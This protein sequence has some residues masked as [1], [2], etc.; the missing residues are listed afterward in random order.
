MASRSFLRRDPV[1]GLGTGP[2]AIARS[3]A[4]KKVRQDAVFLHK[5][6]IDYYEA[7]AP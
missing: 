7:V 1:A 5:I 6:R 3:S 2:S 4:S